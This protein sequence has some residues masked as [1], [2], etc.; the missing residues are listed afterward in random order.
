MLKE[1]PLLHQHGIR[2]SC[3]DSGPAQGQVPPWVPRLQRRAQ[4]EPPSPLELRV[5]D[6][7][8]QPEKHRDRALA[9]AGWQEA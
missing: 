5:A 2:D 4:P 1:N 8:V 3:Q 9:R 6:R 7:L